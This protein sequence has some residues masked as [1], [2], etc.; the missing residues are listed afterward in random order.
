MKDII[1]S[2]GVKMPQIGFGTWLIDNEKVAE[3]VVQAIQ[4]GYRHIDTAQAYGNEE[5]VGN[6]IRQSRISRCEL[7]VTTKIRAEHKDYDSALQSIY[8]SIDTMKLDYLDQIIIH[9]PQPWAEFRGSNRYFEENIAVWRALENAYDEGIVKSIGV[10]NFL[11][12]DAENLIENCRIRPMVNQILAHIG[13]TPFR[14]IDFCRA[15]DIV[16]AAY[17]PIAHGEAFKNV[18]IADIAKKYNVSIPQLC[19]K[20]VLNLGLIA[21]PKTEHAKYMKENIDV[22]FEVSQTDMETLKNVERIKDYGEHSYFPV[23]G[24]KH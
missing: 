13:N 9:S 1:L 21:L 11:T 23:F 19:I 20:Y 4:I 10:S 6:G 14:L 22:N 7:F 5:G 3:A 12:D 17:S 18:V 2:N 8:H 24:G 15:N 16:V